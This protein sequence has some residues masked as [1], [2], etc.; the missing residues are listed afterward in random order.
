MDRSVVASR[1]RKRHQ[2]H[3]KQPTNDATAVAEEIA[4]C[5]EDTVE[6]NYSRV[7]QESMEFNQTFLA[8]VRA[9]ADVYFQW[10]REL[11]RVTSLFEFVE[12]FT[13]C[14]EKQFQ[15][16]TRQA[17]ELFALGESIHREYGTARSDYR[18]C[19]CG[20]TQSFLNANRLGSLPHPM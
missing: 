7:I 3:V 11:L 8:I 12:I 5:I 6:E 16:W 18:W 17:T 14:T 19:S 20:K 15:R 4:R 9:N 1:S 2:I 10:T 13:D